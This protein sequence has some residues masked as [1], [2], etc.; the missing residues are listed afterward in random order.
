MA[1]GYRVH[2]EIT[3][4]GVMYSVAVYWTG[5][6]CTRLVDAAPAAAPAASIEFILVERAF[7]P[8]RN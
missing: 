8:E 2:S 1:L 7:C 4:P 5:G 3:P 6:Y